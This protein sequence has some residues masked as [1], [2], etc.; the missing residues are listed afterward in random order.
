[1]VNRIKIHVNFN[2]SPVHL[3]RSKCKR[4]KFQL[5]YIHE[6]NLLTEY[7]K[8]NY[9][10]VPFLRRKTAGICCIRCN[11]HTLHSAPSQSG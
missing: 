9:L 6:R 1:M 7:T 11:E 10:K 5:K 3:S 4:T 8:T 2:S